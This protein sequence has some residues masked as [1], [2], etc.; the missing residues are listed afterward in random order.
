M[1]CGLHLRG[2]AWRCGSR[3]LQQIAHGIAVEVLSGMVGRRLLYTQQIHCV[4]PP[5]CA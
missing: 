3:K 4:F 1:G 2:L 5:V